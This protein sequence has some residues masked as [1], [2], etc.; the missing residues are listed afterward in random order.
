MASYLTLAAFRLRT[1]MPQVD[2]NVIEGET[3]GFTDARLATHSAKIDTRLR[4]R[5]AVPFSSL[6]PYPEAVLEWLTKIVTFELY[7]KRGVDPADQSIALIRADKE[8]AEAELKEAADAVDGLFDLPLNDTKDGTAITKGA[9][10]AYVETSP[11]VTFDLQ[12][13]DG[14]AD[15]TNGSG[16]S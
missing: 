2:I 12:R 9:P 8:Q 10:L 7:L 11:Y 4:K 3:S 14:R 6:T 16:T 13:T 5:Y 15:D 1:L